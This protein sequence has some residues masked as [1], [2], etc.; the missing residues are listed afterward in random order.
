MRLQPVGE[1]LRGP[2]AGEGDEL[3]QPVELVGDEDGQRRPDP[4]EPGGLG[5]DLVGQRR[6][7]PA[8]GAGAGASA[9]S[10]AG[11][12]PP[13]RSASSAPARSNGSRMTCPSGVGMVRSAIGAPA[14]A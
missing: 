9:G 5:R 12:G 14:P 7:P 8:T 1:V 3:G 4:P 6:A 11:A 13:R 10:T 2:G